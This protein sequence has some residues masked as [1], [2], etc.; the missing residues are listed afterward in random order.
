M[1]KKTKSKKNS[2]YKFKE[3]YKNKLKKTRR[4]PRKNTKK[5]KYSKKKKPKTLKGGTNPK[6]FMDVTG[7]PK[8][9][10]IVQELMRGDLGGT[11]AFKGTITSPTP[12]PLHEP[13]NK[14]RTFLKKIFNEDLAIKY[15]NDIIRNGTLNW[16]KWRDLSGE[17]TKEELKFSKMIPEEDQMKIIEEANKQIKSSPAP[18]PVE[19][20]SLP[21]LSMS[22]Q[23]T[24][25]EVLLRYQFT[26]TGRGGNFEYTATFYNNDDMVDALRSP[27]VFM[28]SIHDYGENTII[29]DERVDSRFLLKNEI[30][31]KNFEKMQNFL[32]KRG[33]KCY[34]RK[35]S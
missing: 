29:L 35:I 21:P 10:P 26:G 3:L 19:S 34:I 25:R 16:S 15:Y 5:R 24:S 1:K 2:I 28:R 31:P 22:S 14:L 20:S 32:E 11:K 33:F 8:D 23:L 18:E 13:E 12:S 7:L 6:Q 4:K 27:T 17:F 30:I 9:Q